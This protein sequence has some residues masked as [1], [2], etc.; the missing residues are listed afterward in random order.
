MFISIA[1]F[2]MYICN[3]YRYIAITQFRFF[4]SNR[5]AFEIKQDIYQLLLSQY[6]K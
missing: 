4:R 5:K 2:V 1:L 3:M 6:F